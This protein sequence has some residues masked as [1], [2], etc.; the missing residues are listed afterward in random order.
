MR[1]TRSAPARDGNPLPTS[2]GPVG[3]EAGRFLS[4]PSI[5]PSRAQ[6]A[7]SAVT[8]RAGELAR[9]AQRLGRR[10]SRGARPAKR[11]R[12]GARRP[13]G[14]R[15]PEGNAAFEEPFRGSARV[16]VTLDF[17][18]DQDLRC[19]VSAGAYERGQSLAGSGSRTGSRDCS[20][21][22]APSTRRSA[23]PTLS[24]SA[25]DCPDVSRCRWP[26][27]PCQPR[28]RA[29]GRQRRRSGRP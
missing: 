14:R 27:T 26:A 18:G 24:Q 23:A 6:P 16:E 29:W 9:S 20:G 17:V 2:E 8:E 11:A 21:P 25:L 19:P 22:Y 12:P 28:V 4:P 7:G 5:A 1:T 10:P 15:R 3:R 13:A